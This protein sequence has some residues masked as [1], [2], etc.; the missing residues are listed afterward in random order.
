MHETERHRII[1]SAIDGRPVVMVGDLVQLTGA[2]EATI[3]RDIA[4]L[5]VQKSCAACAAGPKAWPPPSLQGSM[6]GHFR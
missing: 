2:S 1:L 6:R 4:T 5:H 3:R